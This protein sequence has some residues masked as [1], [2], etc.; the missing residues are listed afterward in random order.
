VIY[1]ANKT[2]IQVPDMP[3]GMTFDN[4]AQDQL[5][6]NKLPSTGTP[7]MPAGGKK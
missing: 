7:D 1:G 6:N 4:L 5:T 3:A 2:G